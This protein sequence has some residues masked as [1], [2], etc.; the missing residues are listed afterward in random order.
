MVS[1][2]PRPVACNGTAANEHT[3]T[4]YKGL[5]VGYSNPINSSQTK[6][7]AGNSSNP[8]ISSST[9]NNNKPTHTAEAKEFSRETF[10]KRVSPFGL[11]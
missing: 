4:L 5:A 7:T 10:Q 1:L 9:S 11:I 2:R 8:A 3:R 6:H